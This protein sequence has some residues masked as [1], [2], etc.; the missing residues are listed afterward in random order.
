MKHCF[1]HCSLNNRVNISAKETQ[2]TVVAQIHALDKDSGVN[3]QLIYTLG[4]RHFGCPNNLFDLDPMSGELRLLRDVSLIDA[5][6]RRRYDCRLVVVVSDQG[7]PVKRSRAVLRIRF[8]RQDLDWTSG[9]SG[10]RNAMAADDAVSSSDVT[11]R[12]I[13]IAFGIG[14]AVLVLF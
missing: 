9:K 8:T 12:K 11:S 7:T 14:L 13:I 4:Q 6:D 5:N 2:G 1:W 10:D 3:G